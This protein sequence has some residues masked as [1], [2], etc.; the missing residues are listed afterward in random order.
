MKKAGKLPG[1]KLKSRSPLLTQ[2][3]ESQERLSAALACAQIG[4]F[5][6][7]IT[8]NRVIYIQPRADTINEPLVLREIDAS[9]WLATTHPDDI[10]RA[11]GAV[12]QAVRGETDGFSMRYRALRVGAIPDDWIIVHS[13][14]RVHTRDATGRATRILGVFE[15]V[16]H[17]AAREE[18]DRQRD[19]HLTRATQLAALSELASSMAH[20]INQPLAALGSYLQAGVRM[21]R[22]E[23][24]SHLEILALLQRCDRQANRLAG[25]VRRLKDLNRDRQGVEESFDLIACLHEVI[26]MLDR[27]IK[28]RGIRVKKN[29]CA[30]TLSLRGDRMQIEQVLYN[31]VRNAVDA[32]QHYGGGRCEIT[33]SVQRTAKRVRIRIA[34]NGPGIPQNIQGRL[35]EPFFTTKPSG[36]GLGLSI[37]RSIIEAHRGR[38]TLDTRT[39]RGAAFVIEL[40]VTPKRVRS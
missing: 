7:D 37:S 3:A 5:D 19:A 1:T 16:T 38:I 25:I 33:A 8:T 31:L 6:W 14:G 21:V 28:D 40:P 15:D 4:V 27:E 20:E 17:L 29:M 30:R 18:L 22:R 24:M 10:A 36:T 34:D 39:K 12:D 13:R 26:A 11:R 9:H 2:L 35:F 23:Q 32:L